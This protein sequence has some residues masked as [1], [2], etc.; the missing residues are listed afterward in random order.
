MRSMLKNSSVIIISSILQLLL[1]GDHIFC[2]D[3][4]A[5]TVVVKISDEEANGMA[6]F[7]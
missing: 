6:E 1:T 4:V 2:Y 3:I 5:C 7:Q